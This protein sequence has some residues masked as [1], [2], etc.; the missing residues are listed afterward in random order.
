MA[1]GYSLADATK[2]LENIDP[3]LSTAR[4]VTEALKQ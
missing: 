2:A 4:R 3:K 1:L